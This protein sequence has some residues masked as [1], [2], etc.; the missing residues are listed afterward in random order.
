M[1][2]RR[3]F[4]AATGAALAAVPP[5]WAEI[6]APAFVAAAR[7]ADGAHAL[8][9]LRD[10]GQIAFR[11]PLPDRGHAAAAHPVRA[12]AVGFAR[13]PGT[14]ALVLDCAE[15]RVLHRLDTPEGRHFYGHGVFVDGGRILATTENDIATGEGRI[16]LWDAANGYARLDEIASGGIG[17]HEITRLSDD[18]L[19]VANGGIRTHPDHGRDKL[20]LDTM[21]P[22][23]AYLVEGRVVETAELADPKLSIR[24]IAARADGTVAIGLQSQRDPSERVPLLATHRRGAAARTYGADLAATCAGYVGSVAWSGDGRRVAITAPRGARAVLFTEG[25]DTPEIVHRPDICGVAPTASGL[26][27]TDG[28]GGVLTDRGA[29]KH[30]LSWDNHLVAIRG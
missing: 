19:V 22:N 4:L 15:G 10:D 12:E 25:D 11:V 5:A 27:F 14:F 16:G 21:R 28:T 17:P 3:G 29:A 2:S 24:H 30:A 26:A 9:G 13:R 23:L 7:E 20:N 8:F 6:G 1:L 18:T